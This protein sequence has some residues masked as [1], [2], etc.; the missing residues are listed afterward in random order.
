MLFK[1][2]YSIY[3]P[4]FIYRRH[5]NFAIEYTEQNKNYDKSILPIDAELKELE[6]LNFKLLSKK[7][8]KYL[9]PINTIDTSLGNNKETTKLKQKN[10][11]FIIVLVTTPK[12]CICVSY[13]IIY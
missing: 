7:S 9:I 6:E 8:D 1:M 11:H 13:K 3:K 5:T 2:D 12:M 4:K 10:T